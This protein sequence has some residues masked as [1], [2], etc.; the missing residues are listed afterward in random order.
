[1]KKHVEQLDVTVGLPASGKT[2]W[3]DNHVKSNKNLSIYHVRCDFR[4]EA[5][6]LED[7]LKNRVYYLSKRNIIDGLF[8][9]VSDIE[10]LV[11]LLVREH[12]SIKKVV[13]HVWNEDRETCMWNDLYRRETKSNIT[14][15]NAKLDTFSDITSLEDMFPDIKFDIQ[16][17]VVE[18]KPAWRVFADKH[19]LYVN[20]GTYEVS[21]EDWCTGGTWADC[22][23]NNGNVGP[24][25]VPEGMSV[26]D[27]L[28]EEVV[29]NISFL[30]YKRIMSECVYIHDFSEDDYYGG[31]TYHKQYK[32]NVASLY[33]YLV[34]NNLINEIT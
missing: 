22:W 11:S 12:V 31:T 8:L 5:V 33:A 4:G 17:H 14:I 3:A 28:L 1:M 32:L 21:G 9:T 6:S 23:G 15:D 7:Y 18:P 29:P 13:L 19:N 26:L 30:Q 10:K 24:D 20:N 34:D 2:T 25:D 16:R 27:K